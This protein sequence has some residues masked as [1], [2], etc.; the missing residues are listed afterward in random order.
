MFRKSR[1]DSWDKARGAQ[2][3]FVLLEVL[4][5]AVIATVTLIAAAFLLTPVTVRAGASGLEF[6]PSVA[7]GEEANPEDHCDESLNDICLAPGPVYYTDWYPK[8]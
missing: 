3:G 1:T 2:S 4:I 6:E 8:T 7:C 5:A